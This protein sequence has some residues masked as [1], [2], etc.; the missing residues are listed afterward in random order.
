MSI[1]SERGRPLAGPR[2]S[3][4]RVRLDRGGYAAGGAYWGVGKPL[5]RVTD[6][7][8]ETEHFRAASRSEAETY[9]IGRWP[10]ATFIRRT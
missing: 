10:Y 7:N 4:R 3:L 8:G 1:L 9:V 5:W 6:A 2:L